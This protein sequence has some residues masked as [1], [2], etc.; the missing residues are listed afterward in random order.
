MSSRIITFTH[1]R[2]GVLTNV[3]SIVLSD[4]TGTFG[5]KRTDTDA[6]VVADGA[7]FTNVSTGVY[8]YTITDPAAG[9]TYVYWI[10]YVFNGATKR[11]ER[12]SSPPATPASNSYLTTDDAD[13]IAAEMLSAEVAAYVAATTPDKGAALVRASERIDSAMQY[14][15]RRYDPAQ[16]MEFPRVAYD[17]G[18]GG[19][20]VPIPGQI[21][22]GVPATTV[23]AV[24]WEWDAEEGEAVV[25][26]RV[27]RACL[28]EANSILAGDRDGRMNAV[29]DGL[30]SQGIGSANESYRGDAKPA[31][32]CRAAHELMQIYR[33]RS[34]QMI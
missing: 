23:A 31:A 19:L 27:K 6:I 10:E 34:G 4:P 32:L 5:A 20:V 8:Q 1:R 2:N 3:D 9:L 25:P 15:G 24:V 22:P 26:G 14:Q 30:A 28:L 7:A 13:A 16:A 18:V 11:F 21:Y 17:G 12:F 33:L 29:H